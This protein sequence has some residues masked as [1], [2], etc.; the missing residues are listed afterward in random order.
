[1]TIKRTRTTRPLRSSPVTG[2]SP[3]LQGGP[4]RC[5]ASVLSPSRFQPLGVLPHADRRQHAAS[6]IGASGSHV[7]HRSLNRARA[8]FAPDDHLARTCRHPPD[9]SQGNN[10]TLVS[11]IVDTL[12]TFQQ[13]FTRVRLLGSH[14]TPSRAPFP[15]RSPPRLIHRRSLRWFATSPCVGGR[16]GPTSITGATPHSRIPTFY[17]GTSLSGRGTPS[18]AYRTSTPCWRVDHCR[19][20]RC[21]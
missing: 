2:P 19:S 6:H 17:T 18:S 10:W 16:G 4:P 3:L 11:I 8:T 20:N 14:L 5:P 1:M 12:S 15:Q 9:P 7:P 13:W 21:R